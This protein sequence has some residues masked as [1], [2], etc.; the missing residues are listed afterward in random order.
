LAG[1]GRIRILVCAKRQ[2]CLS[3]SVPVCLQ[4]NGSIGHAP[5]VAGSP[6]GVSCR[7][8]CQLAIVKS[9]NF[10]TSSEISYLFL[11][12]YVLRYSLVLRFNGSDGF[13][14]D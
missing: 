9:T 11:C 12:C 8:A 6:L 5:T 13:L 7:I 14:A 3:R 2:Y 1:V 4:W 10:V